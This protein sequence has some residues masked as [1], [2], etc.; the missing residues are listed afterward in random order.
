M[1][2]FAAAC[3]GVFFASTAGAADV[4]PALQGHWL[5]ESID[6]G[7]VI[8]RLQTTLEVSAEGNF[9]G[10][11]GCNRYRGQLKLESNGVVFGPAAATRMACPPATMEQEM[12]FFRALGNVVDFAYDAATRKLTLSDKTGAPLVVLARMDEPAQITITVPGAQSVERNQVA[13][14]C[15]EET[16]IADYIN[17]GAVSLVTLTRGETFTVA[18]NVLAA[19]GAKYAGDALVWWVKGDDATLFDLTKGES[20][21]GLTC[22]PEA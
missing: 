20:D 3:V 22:T 10:H 9:Y 14:R 7:G 2:F 1:K 11:G 12:K 8:D 6:G 19:S 17:A 15:G 16:V 4:P 13:Y 18:A 5:A 21:P